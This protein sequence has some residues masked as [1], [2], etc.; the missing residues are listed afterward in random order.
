[1]DKAWTLALVPRAEEL[2]RTLG[3]III[4]GEADL[5]RRI[6]LRRSAV[7]RVEILVGDPRPQTPFTA[8]ELHR[9]FR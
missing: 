1:V 6:E 9:F 8:E 5:V 3:A 4:T 7:Q 2:R